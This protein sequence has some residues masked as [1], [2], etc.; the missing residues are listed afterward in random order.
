MLLKSGGYFK[1]APCCGKLCRRWLG[2]ASFTSPG[3]LN[4]L[5]G[6]YA[7]DALDGWLNSGPRESRM[8]VV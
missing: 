6:F 5:G 1:K 7:F 4:L 3:G 8:N 2:E